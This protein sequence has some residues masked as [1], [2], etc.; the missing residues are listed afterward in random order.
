MDIGLEKTDVNY[1]IKRL[2]YLINKDHLHK[3]EANSLLK[4]EI[5][6]QIKKEKRYKNFTK[7]FETLEEA[8]RVIHFPY[9][10]EVFEPIKVIEKVKFNLNIQGIYEIVNIKNNKR[11]IGLSQNIN[12]RWKQHKYELNYS[13]H[14]NVNLQNDWIKYGIKSFRFN[15]IQE[16]QNIDDL[17]YFERYWWENAIGEKYNDTSHMMPYK[18]YRIKFLEDKVAKLE[19][20]LRERRD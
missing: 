15:V 6:E 13:R 9:W 5:V 2:W 7:Y 17:S 16:I 20:I 11:Y 10:N 19:K 12:E 14:H 18:D 4:E 3:D 8:L 1:Y